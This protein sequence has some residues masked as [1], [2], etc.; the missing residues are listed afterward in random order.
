MTRAVFLDRD[1]VVNE[2]VVDAGVVKAP[3]HRGEVQVPSG[4]ASALARLRD[5]CYFNI[6]ISNQPDIARGEISEQAVAGINAYLKATL[7]LDAIVICPHDNADACLCRKPQ[8]GMILDAAATF[9]IDLSES[10]TVGDRWV[11][12]AAGRA[13][14]TRTVLVERAYSWDPTSSGA[15]PPRLAPDVSVTDLEEGTS[16]ILASS[17]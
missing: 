10:W 1:G 5:H 8:P 15:P 13:A 11:D 16:R 7:P 2:V 6:V 3:R 17:R 14:G 9:G 4:T 12:I